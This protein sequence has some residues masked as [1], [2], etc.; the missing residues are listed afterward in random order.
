MV[1][2][3]LRVLRILRRELSVRVTGGEEELT[4]KPTN[5]KLAGDGC[6]LIAVCHLLRSRR[7]HLGDNWE[8]ICRVLV[9]AK[10]QPRSVSRSFV[11]QLISVRRERRELWGCRFLHRPHSTRCLNV[12]ANKKSVPQLAGRFSSFTTLPL[13]NRSVAIEGAMVTGD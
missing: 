5:C 13:R 12:R 10:T 3:R 7:C 11:G 4:V 8:T 6:W 2:S 1:R 9:S